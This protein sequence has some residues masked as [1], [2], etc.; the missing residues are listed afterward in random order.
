[1]ETLNSNSGLSKELLSSRQDCRS[2]LLKINDETTD[3]LINLIL[4]TNKDWINSTVR[5]KIIS[6]IQNVTV[7]ELQSFSNRNQS[8]NP[9]RELNQ[10]TQ[11]E[12]QKLRKD[13]SVQTFKSDF[14][15]NV[16]HSEI[17]P[18]IFNSV[19]INNRT[20][21][22]LVGAKPQ[23]NSAIVTSARQRI[24]DKISKHLLPDDSVIKELIK[25]SE[26][27]ESGRKMYDLRS[28]IDY[29][30]EKYRR[31]TSRTRSINAGSNSKRRHYFPWFL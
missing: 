15:K 21:S 5:E 16:F 25:D 7:E 18:Q 24:S 6:I 23:L 12:P 28:I 29:E 22:R 26:F 19:K 11:H 30:P 31:S 14:D 9:F 13:T 2:N 1:M 20:S 17:K 10:N 8:L 4:E 27:N 3:K